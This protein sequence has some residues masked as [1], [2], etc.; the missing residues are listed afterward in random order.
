MPVVIELIAAL[1]SLALGGIASSNP[2]HEILVKFLR[3]GR[4]ESQE[5]YAERL[6]RLTDALVKS[7]AEV[8]QV[9]SELRD[10]AKYRADAL[11]SLEEDLAVLETKE[12]ALQSRVEALQS[13]PL[14]VAEHFASLTETGERRSARRD[15]V[16]FGA[17]VVVSTVMA[18]GLKAL[19][20]A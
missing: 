16:L 15:Y 6:G 12:K 10:V 14:P 8:D 7:S 1:A 3:R 4:P 9:L 11:S 13:I 20:L 2:V 17:G 18:I 5:T 19:G